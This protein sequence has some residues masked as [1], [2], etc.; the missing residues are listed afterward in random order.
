MS[1][2]ITYEQAKEAKELLIKYL[3]ENGELDFSEITDKRTD[4][5]VYLALTQEYFLA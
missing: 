4:K 3:N 2:E 1:K 5:I